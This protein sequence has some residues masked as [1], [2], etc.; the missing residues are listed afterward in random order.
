MSLPSFKTENLRDFEVFIASLDEHEITSEERTVQ[1]G[2]RA[3]ETFVSTQLRV[4]C[5]LIEQDPPTSRYAWL[6]VPDGGTINVHSDLGEYIQ[7]MEDV[8]TPF[9]ADDPNEAAAALIRNVYVWKRY[10]PQRARNRANPRPINMPLMHLGNVAKY[11]KSAGQN[12]VKE[13]LS[14]TNEE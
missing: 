13:L 10:I 3:G 2:E 9:E 1:Q 8:G 11:D 5:R 6:R 14:G 7:A 4:G 12:F